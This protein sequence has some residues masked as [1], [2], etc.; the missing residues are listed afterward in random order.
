MMYDISNIHETFDL[1]FPALNDRTE[2]KRGRK[3]KKQSEK[4]IMNEY[5]L[6]NSTKIPN[7]QQQRKIY[8]NMEY[9]SPNEKKIFENKFCKPKNPSQRKLMG[10]LNDPSKK[11]VISTGPAGTG[12]TLFA[13]QFAVRGFMC[14]TFDKIIF[15]RPSVSVDEE[16]GFLPGTL[17]E[18]MA[19]WMRPLYDIL[20]NHISPKEVTQLIEE[21][22]IEI[23]PLGFM[24]GRT[25]KNCCIIADEMQNCT[26]SQMKL[27]L[28]RIGEGTRLFITGD[29]EQ[30]DRHN[31]KN[32]LE[33]FL[34][35]IRARRSNSITSVEFEI[36]DVEREQVVKE[37]LEIYSTAVTLYS[38]E[39]DTLSNEEENSITT[40]CS[41]N[42]SKHV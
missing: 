39:E 42:D 20:Y 23:C 18:K 34:E 12:K 15:T 22:T 2:K 8:E 29:L 7:L 19:P 13:T 41:S 17:E 5:M 3:P 16:L 24:R 21:K 14:G 32:G 36:N 31:E 30:C 11:I 25:F 40:P 33:D 10:Y 38:E 27:I 6:E 35:R 1:G 4:E 37:V 28:T 9:L 26:L